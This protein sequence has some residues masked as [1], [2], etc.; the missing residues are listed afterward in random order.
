MPANSSLAPAVPSFTRTS[1]RRTRR[2]HFRLVA[3]QIALALLV[4]KQSSAEDE[5]KFR[6]KADEQ[7]VAAIQ[8]AHLHKVLVVDFLDGRGNRTENGVYEAAQFSKEVAAR[9]SG[10]TTVNRASWFSLIAGNSAAP[11]DPSRPEGLRRLGAALGCD[12]VVT[13]L[14]SLNDLFAKVSVTLREV[15]TAQELAAASFVPSLIVPP[16]RASHPP[17]DNGEERFYF[18]GLDGISELT[19]IRCDYP[20]SDVRS[21]SS[22]IAGTVILSVL[23]APDGSPQEVDVF[24][25]LNK[26][27][28]RN[29]V[30][31]VKQWRFQPCRDAS[32]KPVPVRA[33]V[34]LHFESD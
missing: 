33:S 20:P 8:A 23:V 4:F 10:F 7:V 22:R 30:Q 26:A 2:S 27:L 34:R 15:S 16:G 25:S 31:T 29:A 6:A 18:P 32:G 9:G 28:D 3:I 12:A 13:G 24:K 1:A 14:L 5:N 11:Y 19:C 21:G 17:P